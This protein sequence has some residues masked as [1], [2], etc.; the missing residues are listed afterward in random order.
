MHIDDFGNA[1]RMLS[2]AY[3]DDRYMAEN[4]LTTWFKYFGKY[5]ADVF[6]DVLDDWIQ[7][8]PKSPQISDLIRKCNIRQKRADA[9][10]EHDALDDVLGTEEDKAAHPFEDG[11]R[12]DDYGKWVQVRV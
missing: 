1:M 7:H 5:D 6:S 8:E 2:G 11:W 3:R 10:K 9:K 12:I 4:V